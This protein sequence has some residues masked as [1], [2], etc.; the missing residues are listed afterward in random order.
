MARR[1]FPARVSTP[2][3]TAE[4]SPQETEVSLPQGTLERIECVIPSGH[5]GLTGLAVQYSGE[6]IFPW[7]TDGWVEGNDEVVVH[8]IGMP[9]GGS[10]VVVV[11][12]NTDDTYD[13]DHL[14]RFVVLDP[15]GDD[16][17]T[18]DLVPL[19]PADLELPATTED[20]EPVPTVGD[21][22]TDDGLAFELVDL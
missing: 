3:S 9:L 2:S 1:T 15:T 20:E 21:V 13:H 6:H 17:R 5:A 10:P 19:A 18:V 14:L 12:Y 22:L 11:T 16:G 7:G 4:A 8:D